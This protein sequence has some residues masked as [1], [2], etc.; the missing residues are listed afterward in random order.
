MPTRKQYSQFKLQ[1]FAADTHYFFHRRIAAE[2]YHSE[3][4]DQPAIRTGYGGVCHSFS[5]DIH[6][7]GRFFGGMD[8]KAYVVFI[9]LY[10]CN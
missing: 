6:P 3:Q 9:R 5:F 7:I 8:D 1:L 4:A 2:Q 10:N